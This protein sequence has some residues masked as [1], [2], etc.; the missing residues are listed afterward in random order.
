MT[1]SFAWATPRRSSLSPFEKYSGLDSRSSSS[2]RRSLPDIRAVSDCRTMSCPG[3]IASSSTAA[4]SSTTYVTNTGRVSARSFSIFA[5]TRT[6][7]GLRTVRSTQSARTVFSVGL[8]GARDFDAL[9]QAAREF[10]AELVPGGR[11]I[12]HTSRPVADSSGVLEISG[13]TISFV[14]LRDLSARASVV[15][16][17][18]RIRFILAVSPAC[19]K[20]AAWAVRS[21]SPRRAVSQTTSKTAATRSSYRLVILA[22]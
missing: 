16:I 11:V 7:T 21:W 9:A 3:S 2:I 13:T 19:S 20:R 5:P 22:R 17:P 14:E 12:L 10:T 1:P 6:S 18:L 8:D 4:S 15:A